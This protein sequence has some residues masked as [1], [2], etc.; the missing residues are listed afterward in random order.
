VVAGA[1]GFA[2]PTDA[3]VFAI[4]E[5]PKD[6]SP[7]KFGP[8]FAGPLFHSRLLQSDLYVIHP[9]KIWPGNSGPNFSSFGGNDRTDHDAI[10]GHNLR[11]RVRRGWSHW[12]RF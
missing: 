1:I 5:S 8:A 6:L 12:S 3:G 10:R 4:D 2:T 11:Q 7:D 9:L